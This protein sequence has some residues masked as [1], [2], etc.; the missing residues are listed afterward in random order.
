MT[1]GNIEAQPVRINA[2][3]GTRDCL[4]E[5]AYRWQYVE[6]A[7]REAARRFG[8]AE[9]R[10]PVIEYT[11]LFARG[12]GDTTDVVEKQ[13][14]TFDDLGGRSITL[15]PEGTAGVCR[16]YL[17]NKLYVGTKPLKLWYGIS[18][19]RNE[20]PQ[21]GRLREFHQ[22]GVEIFGS[23]DMLADAEVI[24]VADSFFRGLGITGL[25]LRINSIGCPACRPIYRKRLMDFL[26][27]HLDRLCDTCKSRYSR[28][29]MRI[30]DCKSPACQEIAAGAPVMMDSL[31]GGCEADFAELKSS[32]DALGVE[33]GID[34]RIVRGLDY[35]TKTAFEFVSDSIGAQ[36]AVC[37]G[38][39]YDHLLKELGGED[40]PGVGFGLGIERL[41]LALDASGA[42]IP[43]PAAPDVFVAYM[44]E[45]A[46]ARALALLRELREKG[47]SAVMDV[48]ARN[49]KGQFKYADRTGAR[50]AAVI[51]ED[52]LLSG[53]A[54]VKDMRTGEQTVCAFEDIAG[55]LGQGD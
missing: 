48:C 15:R 5:Q 43:Q 35:Y 12:I 14:Y 54:T 19:F 51:G 28:N 44:G 37:G 40:V 33:Y 10:T 24:A 26:S 8:F 30:L 3:K 32:L 46:K 41:L 50:F 29:P 34:E 42:E 53:K 31:C 16:A 39:R 23:D 4:P 22:F 1:E 55:F 18:C 47:A 17:E 20:K 36:G 11:E 13:M 6:E 27:G 52:E 7:F 45:A 49:I 38:G 2:L 25:S 21:A 9:I